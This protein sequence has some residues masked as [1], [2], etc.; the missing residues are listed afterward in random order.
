MFLEKKTVFGVSYFYSLKI[1]MFLKSDPCSHILSLRFLHRKQRVEDGMRLTYTHLGFL[2]ARAGTES[3]AI[4][5]QACC[6]HQDCL[7]RP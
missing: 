6:T 7:P 1:S 5:R 2:Q 4:S 3:P